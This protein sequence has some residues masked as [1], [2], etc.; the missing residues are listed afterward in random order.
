MLAFRLYLA[1]AEMR[2]FVSLHAPKIEAFGLWSAGIC[3]RF[4]I[5][6]VQLPCRFPYQTK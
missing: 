6:R 1:R 2:Y 4:S 3:P 5:V